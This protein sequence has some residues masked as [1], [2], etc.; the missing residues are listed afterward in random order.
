MDFKDALLMH[1]LGDVVSG[2]GWIET[3]NKGFH[4]DKK[5]KGKLL[6]AYN[7]CLAIIPSPIIQMLG[8]FGVNDILRELDLSRNR[9]TEVPD[10]FA[11]LRLEKLDLSNNLFSHFPLSICRIQDLRVLSFGYNLITSV[12]TDVCLLQNLEELYLAGH[13]FDV[14]PAELEMLENLLILDLSGPRRFEDFLKF[15]GVYHGPRTRIDGEMWGKFVDESIVISTALGARRMEIFEDFL[16]PGETKL[17]LRAV[18]RLDVRLR[19][20]LPTAMTEMNIPT[21]RSLKYLV[22]YNVGS[23]KLSISKGLMNL[24]QLD[25]AYN[26]LES[27]P[28]E[29][30]N[31]PCLEQ[32][33]Y[34]GNPL[35]TIPKEVIDRGL[36]SILL[37]QRGLG[38]GV[39]KCFRMMLFLHGL[40]GVGK[41]SLL[42][43]LRDSDPFNANRPSTDGI[44][45][46]P[47]KITIDDKMVSYLAQQLSGEDLE[48]V[49]KRL[50]SKSINDLVGIEIDFQTHDFAGQ[51]VYYNS[52]QLFLHDR[53]IDLVLWDVRRG[54]SNSG[55]PFWLN[56]IK[57]GAPKAAVLVI[58]TRIEEV[59]LPE[60][61]KGQ[62]Q[63]DFPQINGFHEVDSRTYKGIDQLRQTLVLTALRQTYMG[64]AVPKKWLALEDALAQP[65]YKRKGYISWSK[66]EDVCSACAFSNQRQMENAADFLHDIGSIM[67]Y[68]DRDAVISG[69]AQIVITNKQWLADVMKCI[70]SAQSSSKGILTGDELK[71]MWRD[72]P[73]EIHEQL[74]ELLFKVDLAFAIPTPA[75]EER[76]YMVPC[77]LSEIPPPEDQITGSLIASCTQRTH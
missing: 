68:S 44:D 64:Q 45:I 41:T 23:Q 48:S 54:Y 30:I 22:L 10:E 35:T 32:I 7:M 61:D 67:H 13:I 37:Y 25:I 24:R 53:A 27:F 77:L 33:F 19:D 16:M 29:L 72:F 70:I 28:E 76:K 55:L 51:E 74:L 2:P 62:L 17:D 26:L 11:I 1:V 71:A 66:F 50:N 42:H 31:C 46:V 60:I 59:N 69:V 3:L 63:R 49:L 6:K 58:G 65:I 38:E 20:E 18:T 52:H 8:S 34:E 9:L 39:T 43:A 47:F 21:L 5:V 4:S 14:V 56:S 12:P 36:R 73:L 40:G 15:S 75:G 57:S